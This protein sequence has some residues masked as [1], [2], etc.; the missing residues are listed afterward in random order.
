[1]VCISIINANFYHRVGLVEF[2]EILIPIQLISCFKFAMIQRV[3]NFL[4]LLDVS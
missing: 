4:A 3:V 2:Q 1:M